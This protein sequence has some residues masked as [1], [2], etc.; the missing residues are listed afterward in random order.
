MATINTTGTIGFRTNGYAVGRLLKRTQPTLLSERFGQIDPQGEKKTKTRKFRRIE[1]ISPAVAPVAEGIVPAGVQLSIT[2]LECSLEQYI[3]VVWITDQ[4]QDFC[5]DPILQ[6]SVDNLGTA[7]GETIELIR[8]AVLKA[9][10]NVYYAG[11]VSSRATVNSPPVLGDLRRISR[12][13]HKNRAI[14]I[15]KVIDASVKYG[16]TPVE[17]AYFAIL[18]TELISDVR[19]ITGFEP[20]C[21]YQGALPNEL[22]KV[23]DFRFLV[24]NVLTGWSAAGASG[25]AYLSGGVPVS[26]ST[27]CDVYP[28][29]FF[30]ENA[31]GIVPFKGKN[32]VKIFVKNPNVEPTVADPA[33]QKGFVSGKM[34]QTAIITQDLWM[35]RLE[36]AAT[37]YPS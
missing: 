8:F 34:Y 17:S 37:A 23:E 35:A 20:S 11:S 3:Q 32:A 26:S 10:T 7:F 5:E 33:A 2:D 30:G 9:G 36:C 27:A 29:L 6:D 1:A 13:L 4:V 24:S 15:S 21:N 12:G 28:I 22:G 16:T 14:Q 31:Y 25:T 18:P 19:S